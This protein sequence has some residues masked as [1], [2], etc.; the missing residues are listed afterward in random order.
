M[1]GNVQNEFTYDFRSDGTYTMRAL[2]IA[3]GAKNVFTAKGT[4]TIKGRE[5]GLEQTF[6]AINDRP[7]GEKVTHE[8]FLLEENGDLIDDLGNRLKKQ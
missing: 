1:G 4:Y 2:Y 8:T 5:V 7:G 3:P 6:F